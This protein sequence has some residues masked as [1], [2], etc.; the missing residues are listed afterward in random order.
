MLRILIRRNITSPK[1]FFY[2]NILLKVYTLLK[3]GVQLKVS[4]LE[5]GNNL[6]KGRDLSSRFS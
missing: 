4:R 6:F 3:D 5:Y 1:G 2:I